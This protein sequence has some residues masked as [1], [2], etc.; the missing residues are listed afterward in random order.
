MEITRFLMSFW[1]HSFWVCED[2]F[3]VVLNIWIDWEGHLKHIYKGPK[4]SH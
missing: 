1:F 2:R 4:N 3:H